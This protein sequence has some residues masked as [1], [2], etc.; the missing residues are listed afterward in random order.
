MGE[1][2]TPVIEPDTWDPDDEFEPD[3]EDVK[4]DPGTELVSTPVTG[5]DSQADDAPKLLG[6]FTPTAW[7]PPTQPWALN[8][9]DIKE[10]GYTVSQISQVK[11]SI[12]WWIGD[13]LEWGEAAYGEKYIQFGDQYSYWTLTRDTKVVRQIPL[14]FRH[15][16][17]VLSYSA[18]LPVAVHRV[19]SDH[20]RLWLIQ[21][22]EQGWTG[23]MLSAAIKHFYPPDPKA[24]LAQSYKS[25][26][27]QPASPNGT[28]PALSIDPSASAGDERVSER[29]DLEIACPHCGAFHTIDPELLTTNGWRLVEPGG[30]VPSRDNGR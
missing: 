30:P 18:H 15:P 3:P 17:E 25:D 8:R 14:D 26:E 11:D 2:F 19:P 22:A 10:W 21:A 16:P 20:K 1:S 29:G 28:E 5:L 4:G 27:G 23:K 9:P 13:L 24:S 7:I 12:H 6:E